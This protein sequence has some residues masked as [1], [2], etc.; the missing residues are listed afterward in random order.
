MPS[1]DTQFDKALLELLDKAYGQPSGERQSFVAAQDGVDPAVRDRALELLASR[2]KTG[3]SIRTGGA[4][5]ESDV[6][7]LPDQIGA[8]KV[9]R[10]IGRGGMGD[11]F[12]AERASDDFDQIVAIKLIK[13]GIMSERLIERFRRERQLLAQLRH[14]NIAHLYDGGET[15]DGAPFIIMEYVDGKS[16][17]EWRKTR[18]P[19]LDQRLELFEQIC[20]AVAFA[21]QNLIIHRDLTPT[22]IL[23][24][25]N[26]EAK[27]IDF[28]I[29]KPQADESDATPASSV[30]ALSLTPG[31]AA[32]ERSQGVGANTLTDIYSLG[33]I[34]EFLT[35]GEEDPELVAIVARASAEAPEDRYPSARDLRDEIHR[36]GEGHPVRAYS[37]ARTY[38][39]RKFAVREKGLVAALGGLFLAL[40]V[41]LGATGWA[42]NRSEAARETAEMRFSQVRDLANFQL[43]ELYDMLDQV[44]GNTGARVEMA[45]RAQAYLNELAQSRSSDSTLQLETA[46]GFVKLAQIQGVAGHP[47]FGEPELA[48]DNLDKAIAI[49]RENRLTGSSEG[50]ASLSQAL[51]YKALVLAHS[52]SK[53]KESWDAIEQAGAALNQVSADQRERDWYEAQRKYRLATLEWAD[54]ELDS[55]KL[56]KYADALE[57]DIEAWPKGMRGG[58]EEFFDRT[59]AGYYRAIIQYNTGEPAGYA[60]AV[61]GYLAADRGYAEIEDEYPN[62]PMALYWRAWNAYY[63]Y[64]A[65]ATIERDKQAEA[66]LLQ[67]QQSVNQL[68]QVEGNDQ[69]LKTFSERLKEAEAEFYSNLGRHS[70]AIKAQGEVIAGREAKIGPDRK[71]RS[72]SDLAYGKAIFGTIHR[73]AGN[74]AE[75]CQNWEDAERLMAELEKQD[76][77]SNYVAALRPGIQANLERCAD[78]EPVSSF[79][80][81]S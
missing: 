80:A 74:R 49:L 7:D 56:A 78:E 79:Q 45:S 54:L 29:A 65:A 77:L 52:D 9:L 17:I 33:K 66:L 30:S 48:K 64:A 37:D 25:D 18:Q 28:G 16:L 75:A 34:L 13:S 39:W 10:R 38:H 61:D 4:S 81:L 57:E 2:D 35:E 22:N 36:F 55:E 15:E 21:H 11:V 72:V 41:G 63:G 51:A 73:K 46:R 42:Y 6:G 26:S 67:A 76:A 5:I 24:T 71:P 53:P 44:V 47:N 12:L 23:V 69:S 19:A 14:K 8:Y 68:I 3:S 27:L 40:T 58:F 62:E 20:E 60:R 43:F 31:F 50:A 1:G 32:P 70:E 59:L